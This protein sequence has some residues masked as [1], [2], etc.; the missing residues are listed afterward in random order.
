MCRDHPFHL[1]SK[2]VVWIIFHP[3][4]WGLV[5]L[6]GNK[7]LKCRFSIQ[8]HP[9]M[10][11]GS[12]HQPSNHLSVEMLKIPKSRDN[13]QTPVGWS[14]RHTP[15][16]F[17]MISSIQFHSSATFDVEPVIPGFGG[18]LCLGAPGHPRGGV[19]HQV[20]RDQQ[21]PKWWFRTLKDQEITCKHKDKHWITWAKSAA[22]IFADLLAE[23]LT[24]EAQINQVE[25]PLLCWREIKRDCCSS[26]WNSH[27]QYL[28]LKN[29]GIAKAW[30][31]TPSDESTQGTVVNWQQ[32]HS[33]LDVSMDVPGPASASTNQIT[34][35]RR[36]AEIT[37]KISSW[38]SD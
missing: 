25:G 20:W 4:M 12:D 35:N 21:A 17:S 19:Y 29:A 2:A 26:R 32:S 15:N 3:Q 33:T 18:I 1:F 9:T 37:M 30:V 31:Q 13:S 24:Y 22:P 10:K 7:A 5:L 8:S 27:T 23:L 11:K 34:C 16:I 36:T 14:F 28:V 38:A 6:W